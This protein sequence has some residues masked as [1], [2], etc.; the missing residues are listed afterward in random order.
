MLPRRHR[1]SAPGDFR[2]VSRGGKR[3]NSRHL[4]VHVLPSD[5]S[6]SLTIVGFVVSRAVGNAVTRNLVKRRA[7]E[8]VASYLVTHPRG[9]QIV[10]RAK[11]S[12]SHATFAQL[13]HEIDD[14]LKAGAR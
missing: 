11:P 3:C 7:R 6:S 13:Q 14:A 4:T 9:L 5:D 8:I 12:A 2:K 1:L 10:V